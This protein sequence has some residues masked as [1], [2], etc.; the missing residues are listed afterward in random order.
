MTSTLNRE[1]EEYERVD[2][3]WRIQLGVSSTIVEPAE[4]A[5][6]LFSL[7]GILEYASPL[8]CS[9]VSMASI[10]SG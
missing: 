7:S 5:R 9:L 2:C 8:S 1:G 4:V 6:F 10:F 3:Q